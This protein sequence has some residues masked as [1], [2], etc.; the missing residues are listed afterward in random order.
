LGDQ[1]EYGI[2]LKWI[3]KRGDMILR[4]SKG[5]QWADFC[6]TGYTERRGSIVTAE[7]A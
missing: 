7:V 4:F 2:I 3:L 5:V 6:G 1:G